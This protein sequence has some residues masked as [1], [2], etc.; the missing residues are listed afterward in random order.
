MDWAAYYARTGPVKFPTGPVSGWNTNDHGVNNAEGALA[1]PA[2]DARL[3]GEGARPHEAM[4][5]V[6]R[7]LDTYQAQPNALFCADEVF[8]TPTLT[9]ALTPAVT[10]TPTPTRP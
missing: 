5:L 4:A 2:M 9:L 1:W 6:L 10:R 8:L 3:G 7:M